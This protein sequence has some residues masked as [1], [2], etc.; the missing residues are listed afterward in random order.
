MVSLYTVENALKEVYLGVLSNQLNTQ[1]SPVLAKINHSSSDVWGKEIR[2]LPNWYKNYQDCPMLV[3]NVETMYGKIEISDKAIRVSQNSTGALVNLLNTELESLLRVTIKA[4][5]DAFFDEDKEFVEV[6]GQKLNNHTKIKTSGLKELFSDSEKIYG[7]ERAKY[8][9][10]NPVVKTIKEFN[11]YEI[12]EIIDNNNDRVDF[13]IC[14]PKVKRKYQESFTRQAIEI[15]ELGSFKCLLFNGTIPIIPV[16]E[17]PENEIYFISTED[18]TLHQ[19]CDWKWLEDINGHILRQDEA[20]PFYNASLVKY[21]NYICE[22]PYKQ[23][24]IVLEEKADE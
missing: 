5:S 11:P 19:L 7:L 10:L 23:I 22:N 4:I 17:V 12:Q 8:V 15:Q 13:M 6:N 9:E 3:S 18:F 2:K 20:K 14:N 1:V 21:G 16:R 24:K